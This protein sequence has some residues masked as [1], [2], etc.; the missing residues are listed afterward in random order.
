MAK[1]EKQEQKEKEQK[2]REKKPKITQK[3]VKRKPVE[4]REG[5]RGIIRI[6]GKDMQ[7]ELPLKRALLRIKGI[8]HATA[9]P[10][11]KAIQNELGIAPETQVGELKDDQIDKIDK[12]L[13]TLQDYKV[14]TFLLNRRDD[15]DSGK[16]KH[17]IMNDLI[18]HVEQDIEREKKSYSWKGYRH[19]YGQKV[20]GQRTRNTGRKGM[21]VGVLRKAVLAQ[22]KA[23]AAG[24]GAPAKAAATA[25]APAKKEEKASK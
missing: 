12:M 20:R 7:G 17:I 18:F 3:P 23:A 6:A 9:I 16:N 24:T 10:A 8:N 4:E 19:A 21:A 22:Q 11:C 25:A 2:K 1:K 14:P 15:F 13:F 5:F